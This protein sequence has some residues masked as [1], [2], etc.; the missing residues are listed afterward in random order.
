MKRPY[1]KLHP[2][3]EWDY[4]K[5]TVDIIIYQAYENSCE[6]DYCPHCDK[7]T[8]SGQCLNEYAKKGYKDQPQIPNTPLKKMTLQSLLDILPKDVTPSDVSMEIINHDWAGVPYSKLVFSYKKSFPADMK[9][10]KIDKA[11]YDA[12]WAEYE[13]KEAAYNEWM[14]QQEIKLLEDKIASLKK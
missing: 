14:K 11:A 7:K 12:E 3:F 4:R 1:M 5:R 9:Q 8:C 10:F 2:V 13:K 6:G